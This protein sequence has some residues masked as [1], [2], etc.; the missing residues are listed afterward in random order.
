[1]GIKILQ[2]VLSDSWCSDVVSFNPA[3]SW[4]VDTVYSSLACLWENFKW[5]AS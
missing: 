3:L 4:S 5:S 2:S 1:L